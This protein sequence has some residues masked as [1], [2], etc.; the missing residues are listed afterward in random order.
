MVPVPRRWFFLW[1]AIAIAGSVVVGFS[2]LQAG[3]SFPLSAMFFLPIWVWMLFRFPYVIYRYIKLK[4]YAHE[5]DGL[6]CTH[7]G[8]DMSAICEEPRC[9]ECGADWD[10]ETARTQWARLKDAVSKIGHEKD[11]N[12]EHQDI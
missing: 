4:K 2:D 3:F 5:K 1:I 10:S 7:C 6:L 9:P 11:S 8:Y 12:P